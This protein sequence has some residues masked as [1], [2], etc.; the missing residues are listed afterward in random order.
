MQFQHAPNQE[1]AADAV[2]RVNCDTVTSDQCRDQKWQQVLKE[3]CPAACGFCKNSECQDT[4]P[5]CKKDPTIC[6]NVDMQTFV[7]EYCK[8]TCGYCTNTPV[9][10]SECGESKNCRN[11]VA[12]GFCTNPFYDD[13]YRKK[14]CG[15]SCG[16]CQP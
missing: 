6:R 3:D 10:P 13:K 8:A 9:G 2:P 11:W 15:K 7:K 4:V 12:H 14:Y 1:T 16:L 5:D